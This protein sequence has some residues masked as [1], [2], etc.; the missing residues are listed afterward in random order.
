MATS[1]IMVDDHDKSIATKSVWNVMTS[2]GQ[3]LPETYVL[4]A[5]LRG[6][7]Y[8]PTCLIQ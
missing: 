1:D 7:R 6:T 8:L 5:S 4:F 2:R 3:S